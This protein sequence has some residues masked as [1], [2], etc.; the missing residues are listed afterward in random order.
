MNNLTKRQIRY[1][2]FRFRTEAE[3]GAPADGAPEGL[4]EHFEGLEWFSSWLEF[5]IV[6]DVKEDS[7]LEM[8]RL[9]ENAEKEW[10]KI[11]AANAKELVFHKG[12]Y[13]KV[14][15]ADNIDGK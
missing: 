1:W 9:K 12:K 14:K 13:V 8:V 2:C 15:D 7:P 6:W 5:S 11:V 4:K 3:G 10:E